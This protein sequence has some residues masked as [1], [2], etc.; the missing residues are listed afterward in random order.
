MTF[1]HFANCALLTFGPSVIFYKAG[2]LYVGG[3]LARSSRAS[4]EK[5]ENRVRSIVR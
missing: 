5:I 4:I 2:K 3:C 1:L